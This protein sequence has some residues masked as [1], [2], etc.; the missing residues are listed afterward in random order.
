MTGT[1][2]D[3]GRKDLEER[4]REEAGGGRGRARERERERGEARERARYDRFRAN[5][6]RNETSIKK[7]VRDELLREGIHRRAGRQRER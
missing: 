3:E 4:E 7:G 6:F 1:L 2:K 5:G